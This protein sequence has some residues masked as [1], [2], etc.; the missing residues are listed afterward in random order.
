M[1]DSQAIYREAVIQAFAMTARP[2][3]L[4]YYPPRSCI[5]ST[6][7]TIECLKRFRLAVRP[8]P[9]S[10]FV[11]IPS[12]NL[13]YCSG[14]SAEDRQRLKLNNANVELPT[15]SGQGWQG[16]VVAHVE[17]RWL[18]DPSFDQAFFSFE[19]AGNLPPSLE[20]PQIHVLETG[21]LGKDFTLD[22]EGEME[23]GSPVQ[24]Q[25][26]SLDDQSFLQTPA[27]ELDSL[28]QL[29]SDRIARK[30]VQFLGRNRARKEAR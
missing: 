25:Y 9:V 19:D 5:A 20:T 21:P 12:R 22:G 1:I 6:R 2:V 27:W 18:V 4:R 23:D 3:L 11:H 16:H 28:H 26:L 13:L 17:E 15:V 14:A 24:I 8:V 29:A 10:F 7:V 30:M